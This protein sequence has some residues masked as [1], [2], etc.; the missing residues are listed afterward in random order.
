MLYVPFLQPGRVW[1]GVKFFQLSAVL[2]FHAVKIWKFTVLPLIKLKEKS[3]FLQDAW[4]IIYFLITH[5]TTEF[6]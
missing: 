1:G 2:Q 4:L 5:F 6:D 3:L